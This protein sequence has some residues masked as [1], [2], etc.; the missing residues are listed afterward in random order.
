M[1]INYSTPKI[2]KIHGEDHV[3]ALLTTH[4]VGVEANT[5]KLRWQFP[6]VNE[7]RENATMPVLVADNTVLIS[8]PAVGSRCLKITKNSAG[9][10]VEE[11]WSTRKL[12]VYHGNSVQ[13]GDY[14]YA[15]G[16]VMGPHFLTSVN[17][18]TGKI[19][20]RERGFGSANFVYADGRFI[21]L[22]EDGTLLLAT[23]NPD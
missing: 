7:W 19:A 13:L 5:G 16:G 6:C 23:A 2:M 18:R 20:W 21:I 3:V 10:D 22:D 12:Q 8:G 11:A 17:V 1:E 9:F 14:I 15:S 4:V